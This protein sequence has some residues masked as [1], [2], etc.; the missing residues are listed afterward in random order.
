M[1]TLLFLL[2]LL[3][4]NPPASLPEFGF[5]P[6]VSRRQITFLASDELLG[7]MTGEPGLDTAAAYIARHFEK[8]GLKPNPQ[9][10]TYFQPFDA[11]MRSGRIL[12]TQNVVGIIEGTDPLLKHEYVLVMAHYDHVGARRTVASLT[13]TIFNGARDNAMGVVA[14]MHV[15]EAFS[16]APTRRSVVILPVSA[17]EIGLLGSRH[18]IDH[19]VVPLEQTVFVSNID[20][21]GY[22]TTKAVTVIGLN[23]TSAKGHFEAAG[24]AF[25]LNVLDDPA[26]EQ[27]LFNRSDNVNFANRGIPAPTF[28]AG[29]TAF[30]AEIM[31]YYHQPADQADEHFDF[32]YLHRYV[33]VFVHATRL[34]ADSDERIVWMPGDPYEAAF[35]TLYSNN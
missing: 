16:K 34:I 7:R 25:G 9:T 11:T 21:A 35:H 29:F 26:P 17:E 14:L 24:A 20:G 15:A 3:L 28:S 4:G 1:S 33:Q 23:R 2:L 18:Y 31:K 10:G 8:H 13:D 22:N 32:A 27:G 12:K 19:P 5:D 6:E 30:D